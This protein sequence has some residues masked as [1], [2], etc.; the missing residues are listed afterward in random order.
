MVLSRLARSRRSGP[1]GAITLDGITHEELASLIG[2]VREVASR[3][4]DP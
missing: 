2:T 1:D 3:A 4:L